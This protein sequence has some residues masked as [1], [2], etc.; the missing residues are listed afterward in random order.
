MNKLFIKTMVAG[1][2]LLTTAAVNAQENVLQSDTIKTEKSEEIATDMTQ[3]RNVMLNASDDRGPRSLNIGLPASSVGINV[4]ENGLPVSYSIFPMIPVKVWRLDTGILGFN[5]N[6]IGTSAIEYGEVGYTAA[7][8]DNFGIPLYKNIVSLK[9]N[10]YG[11]LNGSYTTAGEFGNH[12]TMYSFTAMGNF[13]PGTFK[14]DAAKY[15]QDRTFSFKGALSQAYKFGGTV[16][17]IGVMYRYLQSGGLLSHSLPYIYRADGSIDQYRDFEIGRTS[18]HE[19]SG[20]A[21]VKNPYTGEIEEFSLMDAK[22]T[23]HNFDLV[24]NMRFANGWSSNTIFR[25]LK[26][27]GGG[28]ASMPV[29]YVSAAPGEYKYLNGK[30]YTRKDAYMGITMATRDIPATYIGFKTDLSKR[31]GGHKVRAALTNMYFNLEDYLLTT[32]PFY[33]ELAPNPSKIVPSATFNNG[34]SF[35][36]DKYGNISLGYNAMIE[37]VD[38]WENKTSLALTDSWKVSKRFSVDFGGRIEYHKMNGKYAPAESRSNGMLDKSKFK[39]LEKDYINFGADVNAVWKAFKNFGFLINGGVLEK[40]PELTNYTSGED[41]DLKKS[42]VTNAGIGIYYNN[43]Y[44]SVISKGTYIKK[45]NF[46]SIQTFSAPHDMTLTTK[47]RSEYDIE[48]FGWTTDVV[49]NPFAGFDLHFMFTMQS[50]KYKNY[51]G[52]CAFTD[53]TRYGFDFSGK[54][55][56]GISKYLIEID[57]SYTFWKKKVKVWGSARYFSEQ[58]ANKSNNLTFVPRWE[59]FVGL[60][61]YP[62][63]GMDLG[64]TVVNPFNQVGASGTIPSTDMLNKN[65][66]KELAIDQ[67]LPGGYMRPFTVEFSMKYMF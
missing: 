11:L 62:V 36:T 59:T 30:E 42:L 21:Q 38:G 43:P 34:T 10:H 54:I 4:I 67:I 16:G 31:F 22:F 37:Y 53:G 39:K 15:H 57:P 61:I 64:V 20:L 13:D 9:S 27:K 19:R 40:S 1:G 5:L 44:F 3:N 55:V 41:N 63:K 29:S 14:S 32:T 25:I 7:V 47:Q 26:A 58:Y 6:T 23:S 49:A 8:T 33:E 18:F 66:V 45:S 60:N 17:R 52:E 12:L 51:S 2:C 28:G 46:V 56:D 48:T 35:L 50:P 24:N 65:Q